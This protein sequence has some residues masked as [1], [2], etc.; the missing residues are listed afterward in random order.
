MSWIDE[1]LEWFRSSTGVTFFPRI[2][3]A[4]ILDMILV[5]FIIYEIII[6]FRST[7]AWTLFKGVIVL[8][9]VAVLASVI[10]M[11][12][13]SWILQNTMVYGMLALVIIFQ[14]EIRKALE[15][16]G[17]GRFFSLFST[18]EQKKMLSHETVNEIIEAM[19]EMASVKTGALI[20]I[21][22]EVPLGEYEQTGIP[23][24]AV[25]TSQL[26]INIFEKNTPL[27]DG[28]VVIR[29][30]RVASATCYLPLSDNMS[31]SKAM[32]TRHRS[33]LGLSEVS[34]AIVLVVSEETGAMSVARGG[35]ITR[36]VNRNDIARLFQYQKEHAEKNTSLIS[37]IRDLYASDSMDGQKKHNHMKQSPKNR[38]HIERKGNGD[39]HE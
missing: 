38:H 32:G 15:R 22:Q 24:D 37:K 29:G 28:A 19:E 35:K 17:H 27:H 23:V 3:I 12:V 5:T 14:P 18:A 21:E 33:A 9:L 36:N 2:G 34:D 31:I 16:L 30:N 7:R 13:T 25:V 26:L 10:K 20:C 4:D 11:N 39:D 6:W 8:V 1:I